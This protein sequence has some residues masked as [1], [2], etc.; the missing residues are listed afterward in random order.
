MKF[1]QKNIE[2]WQNWKMSFFLVSHFEKKK[3]MSESIQD[4]NFRSCTTM[5]VDKIGPKVEHI[6]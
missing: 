4:L 1:S 3:N 6:F 5:N 2:N